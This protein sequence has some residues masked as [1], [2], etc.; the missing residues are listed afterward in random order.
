M[1][2]SIFCIFIMLFP[3]ASVAGEKGYTVVLMDIGKSD[4]FDSKTYSADFIPTRQ[5]KEC[6]RHRVGAWEHRFELIIRNKLPNG[7][8]KEV[9]SAI[10]DGDQEAM[11]Q[12][13]QTMK[14]VQQ[15]YG[16]EIDGMYILK[17]ERDTVSMMALGARGPI[18]AKNPSKKLT[19]FWSDADPEKSAADFDLAL[20]KVAKPLGFEFNP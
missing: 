3:L 4:F 9:A 12:A 7:M 16:S 11:K 17:S 14:A 19:V 6:W 10:W 20:C 1:L 18:G 13:Q 2:K 8:T 5:W 15:N